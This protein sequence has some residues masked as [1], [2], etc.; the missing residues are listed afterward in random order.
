VQSTIPAYAE[1]AEA[2]RVKIRDKYADI[3]VEIDAAKDVGTLR[4]LVKGMN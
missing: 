4:S 1:K 2:E 3:Q